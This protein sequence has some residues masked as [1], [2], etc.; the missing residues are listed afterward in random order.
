MTREDGRRRLSGLGPDIG[1]WP[2]TPWQSVIVAM[3]FFLARKGLDD[4]LTR[5]FAWTPSVP[6]VGP[7]YRPADRVDRRRI[8][9]RVAAYKEE[10]RVG[11]RADLAL[12]LTDRASQRVVRT[13]AT[14]DPKRCLDCATVSLGVG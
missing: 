9:T 5:R 13:S 10:L 3:S 1:E 11:W 8:T 7:L 14:I 4:T 6:R 12:D 2:M